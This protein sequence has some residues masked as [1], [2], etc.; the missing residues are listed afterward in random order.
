MMTKKNQLERLKEAAH[1]LECDDDERR[2]DATVKNLASA[3]TKKKTEK[4]D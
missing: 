3:G 2:F 1:E 4:K